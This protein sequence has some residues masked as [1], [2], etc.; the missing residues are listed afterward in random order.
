MSPLSFVASEVSVNKS[1]IMAVYV[2]STSKMR[3][4]EFLC[5][6]LSPNLNL[7]ILP[8]I[9]WLSEGQQKSVHEDMDEEG[10]RTKRPD[11]LAWK[12]EPRT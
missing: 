8:Y 7:S 3:Y 1:R 4:L 12:S 6:S 2:K 9:K 11:L 10:E 5:S